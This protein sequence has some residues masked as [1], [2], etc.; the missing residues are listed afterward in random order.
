[1]AKILIVEDDRAINELLVN[2]LTLVGHCCKQVFDGKSAL[3]S[4]QQ[5]EFDLVILDI[6]LP[7]ISGFDIVKQS[8]DTAV[9]FLTSR[10]AVQDRVRGLNLGADD[11]II[12]PFE[13]LELLA[14]VQAVL[15]RTKTDETLFTFED[16]SVDFP[17]RKVFRNNAIIELTPQ[18]FELLQILVLNRNIAL[19]RSKL[20]ELAWGY[21]YLGD[22]RTIDVHIQKLRNKLGWDDRIKTVYK[23]GYR[24]EV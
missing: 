3:L 12:K 8:E 5:S 2:N 10:D 14:R 7:D 24:L 13:I 22:T 1:M 18:E 15:R 19:S 16:V 4:L 17:A 20:L 23:V 21:D 11:Y 9:I 6:M